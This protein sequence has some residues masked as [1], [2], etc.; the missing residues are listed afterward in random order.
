MRS[1]QAQFLRFLIFERLEDSISCLFS[2]ILNIPI[3]PAGTTPFWIPTTRT[4][5]N[6]VKT[7][8]FAK[9]FDI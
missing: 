5:L 1:S 2:M 3:P 4:R 8:P 7:E 6:A 9:S